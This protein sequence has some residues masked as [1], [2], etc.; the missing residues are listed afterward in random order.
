MKE[1]KVI[2]NEKLDPSSED[3]ITFHSRIG[4][5]NEMLKKITERR[6]EVIDKYKKIIKKMNQLK[7][8]GII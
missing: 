4:F 1:L 7:D 2:T 8:E 3:F 5:L 6:R